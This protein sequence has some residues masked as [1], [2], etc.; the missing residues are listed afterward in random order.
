MAVKEESRVRCEE[1]TYKQY[2]TSDGKVFLRK[3]EADVHDGLLQWSDAVR[4]FGVK[5]T[6]GAYHCR[7]EEEFNAVVNMIAYETYAYDCNER[8]FVPQN[9]YENYKF[10]GDDWY[11]FF[12]KSNMDYPDE[13]WME[14]LSQKKQEFADWLKQFE[15]SA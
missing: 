4:N 12:H 11:F 9:Y 7:T 8:K 10:S 6:G 15:E 13:Y 3:S 5:N 1:I 2:T 14:T